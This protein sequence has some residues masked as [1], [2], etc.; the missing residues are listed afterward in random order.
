MGGSNK[1]ESL[2]IRK[3]CRKG[4]DRY[5]CCA[6]PTGN[7]V[8]FSVGRCCTYPQTWKRRDITVGHRFVMR[9]K[10]DDFALINSY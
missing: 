9:Y 1:R 3:K 5:R 10:D 6:A 8:K 2:L 4:D 7:A